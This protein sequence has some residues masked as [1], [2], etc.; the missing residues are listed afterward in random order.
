MQ[1][2]FSV[3]NDNPNTIHNRLKAR[4][5]REPTN[6]ELREEVR[7]ILSEVE[8]APTTS[9]SRK[10]V[11]PMTAII[12][13]EWHGDKV[14]ANIENTTFEGVKYRLRSFRNGFGERKYSVSRW[15]E[16]ERYWRFLGEF[17]D[18]FAARKHAETIAALSL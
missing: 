3:Q 11:E 15:E 17:D 8:C 6:E 16:A 10:G 13:P 14:A 2:T 12:R 4:L 9:N 18:A 5:G 1:V 7:R